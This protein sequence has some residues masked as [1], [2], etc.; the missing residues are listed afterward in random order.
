[1]DQQNGAAVK[2]L[3]EKVQALAEKLDTYVLALREKMDERDR[4]YKERD[5]FRRVAVDAALIA[6]KEQVQFAFE[7]SE[8]AIVKA[9]NAQ[10]DY[11]VRSNEFRGQLD[12]QA[13]RLIARTEVET[14]I[15]NIEEK[16]SAQVVDVRQLRIDFAL[17]SG[18]KVGHRETVTDGRAW[19]GV[20]I[21]AIGLLMGIVLAVIG[22]VA[23]RTG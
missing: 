4:L 16:I 20:V 1:M 2:I 11:N 19:L 23:G 6:Q 5:E 22:Y 9:E 7:A 3:Q 18:A 15:K 12:D 13:K 10:K 17:G 8:K 14:L 21:S